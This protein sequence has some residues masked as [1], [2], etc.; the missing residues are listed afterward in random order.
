[1]ECQRKQRKIGL[2]VALHFFSLPSDFP[3]R[4]P[5]TRDFLRVREFLICD[6][7]YSTAKICASHENTICIR[8]KWTKFTTR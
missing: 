6:Y 3:T 5:G 2:A 1:M 4:G 8:K 7:K